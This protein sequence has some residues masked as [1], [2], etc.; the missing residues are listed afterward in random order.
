MSQTPS[1]TLT[2]KQRIGVDPFLLVSAMV[3]F[4]GL[5]FTLGLWDQ[6]TT[7]ISVVW[8]ERLIGIG[9][10]LGASLIVVVVAMLVQLQHR[11]RALA[12]DRDALKAAMER[13]DRHLDTEE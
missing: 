4:L 10:G 9:L 12:D 3:C 1:D 2:V 8:Q 11:H 13:I 5:L 6:L 7:V